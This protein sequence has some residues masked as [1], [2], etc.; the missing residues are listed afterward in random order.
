MKYL[1]TAWVG[2]D[3]IWDSWSVYQKKNIVELMKV[4]QNPKCAIHC[5]P[6]VRCSYQLLVAHYF[7]LQTVLSQ[8]E[9]RHIDYF[10]LDVEGL[11]EEVLKTINWSKTTVELFTIEDGNEW[12]TPNAREFLINNFG[13]SKIQDL[14]WDSVVA[15]KF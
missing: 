6:A 1:T 13:Y 10:S 14:K 11:E 12:G 15:K 5:M 9:L 8:L 7:R 4:R 2:L 3:G